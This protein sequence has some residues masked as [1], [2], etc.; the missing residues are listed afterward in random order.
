MIRCTKIIW[1]I[2]NRNHCL[3]IR[4]E[5]SIAQVFWELRFTPVGFLGTVIAGFHTMVPSLSPDWS[6]RSLCDLQIVLV[7][8]QESVYTTRKVQKCIIF[9]ASCLTL[10][11][12]KCIYQTN[13]KHLFVNAR[14]HQILFFK[15]MLW[16]YSKPF[17][18][19]NWKG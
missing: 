14:L 3:Q 1:G 15:P 19:N 5:A 4:K 7:Y 9:N 8:L 10:P 12:K 16:A 2:N 13:M 17:V 11:V 6:T 18:S